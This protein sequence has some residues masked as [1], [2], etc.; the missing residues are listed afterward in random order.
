MHGVMHIGNG[1]LGTAY[2]AA[3]R[4]FRHRIVY[5]SIMREIERAW[6]S[7]TSDPTAAHAG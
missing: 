6:R 2:M 3:I 7:R 4:P 5:P 1:L